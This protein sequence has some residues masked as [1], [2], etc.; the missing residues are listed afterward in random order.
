MPGQNSALRMFLCTKLRLGARHNCVRVIESECGHIIIYTP[1]KDPQSEA[2]IKQWRETWD[3]LVPSTEAGIRLHLSEIVGMACPALE[4][5]SWAIKAQG[6]SAIATVTEK[7]SKTVLHHIANNLFKSVFDHF[8]F[9]M[10]VLAHPI[11]R[12]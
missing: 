2:D 9:Q 6:A 11:Y 7:M 3:E 12:W 10:R 1:P 5:Q 4:A 8:M